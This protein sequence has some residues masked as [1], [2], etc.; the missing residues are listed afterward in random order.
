MTESTSAGTEPNTQQEHTTGRG[1]AA[2]S[3]TVATNKDTGRDAKVEVPEEL[4]QTEDTEDW[5]EDGWDNDANWGDMNVSH[6]SYLNIKN[7]R[8]K[9]EWIKSSYRRTF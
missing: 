6:T 8:R 2:A 1:T 4:G 3:G 9:F 5:A 7:I